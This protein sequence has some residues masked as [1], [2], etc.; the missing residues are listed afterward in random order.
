MIDN[1][2]MKRIQ[3]KVTRCLGRAITLNEV[4]EF[5]YEN[6]EKSESIIVKELV[7]LL[8]ESSTMIAKVDSDHNKSLDIPPQKESTAIT[9][10]SSTEI[11]LLRVTEENFT[12]ESDEVKN[13]IVGYLTQQTIRSAQD[14]K[15][16]LEKLRNTELA[17]MR[18]I[19]GDHTS[20]RRSE[21]NSLKSALSAKEAQ[22]VNASANFQQQLDLQLESLKREFG[23][24]GL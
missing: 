6:A 8:T 12:N 21:L 10:P 3:E 11:D 7:D 19:Y 24:P 9:P 17:L 14:L 18:Q 4:R 22:E 23:I 13:S 1:K 5:V 16:A 20:R 15:V 2:F